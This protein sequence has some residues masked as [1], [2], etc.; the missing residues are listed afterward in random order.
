MSYEKWYFGREDVEEQK[1]RELASESKE[2]RQKL[3]A[4]QDSQ[5]DEYDEI[6]ASFEPERKALL[7][8]QDNEWDQLDKQIERERAEM[9]TRHASKRA[10]L[11]R[12]HEPQA[13]K[14][15]DTRKNF[16]A[17]WTRQHDR[18]KEPLASA[19]RDSEAQL[20]RITGDRPR[21]QLTNQC[22]STGCPNYHTTLE[23]EAFRFARDAFEDM[24]FH[25]LSSFE[26][27]LK[28]ATEASLPKVIQA[29]VQ[30]YCT[31][32][33]IEYPIVRRGRASSQER[34][35]TL[36]GKTTQALCSL[37]Q[38]P[39]GTRVSY[40]F[41]VGGRLRHDAHGFLLHQECC[42]LNNISLKNFRNGRHKS[43]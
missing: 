28:E 22:G 31:P 35:W 9:E 18:Q 39:C 43:Q 2:R 25:T 34:V 13:E 30:G 16:L 42:V 10:D 21:C 11:N 24:I 4:L 23:R 37:C 8:S 29:I 12:K 15:L 32:P 36:Q 7:A 1:Q 3:I 20:R 17:R 38:E 26:P 27:K 5:R 33:L 41:Y 40:V 6:Y 19:F 14:F